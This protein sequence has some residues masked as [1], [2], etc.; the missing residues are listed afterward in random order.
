[1]SIIRKYYSGSWSLTRFCF[2]RCSIDKSTAVVGFLINLGLIPDPLLAS[3]FAS[4]GM[5]ATPGSTTST[6]PLVFGPLENH[7][8]SNTIFK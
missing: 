3:V 4:V 8:N 2:L 5:I 1:M 6:G 7:L